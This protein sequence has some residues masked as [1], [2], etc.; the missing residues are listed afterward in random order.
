MLS[1]KSFIVLAHTFGPL[2]YSE[3]IFYIWYEV[4]VQFYFFS[5]SF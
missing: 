4:G 5:I 1:S 2:I 3:L